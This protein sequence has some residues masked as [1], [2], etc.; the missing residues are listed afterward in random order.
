MWTFQM[1]EGAAGSQYC[2]FSYE[3]GGATMQVQN[4]QL[5]PDTGLTGFKV[6]DIKYIA[7]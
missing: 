3:G 2:T 4:M 6:V 5:Y 1:C 7:D